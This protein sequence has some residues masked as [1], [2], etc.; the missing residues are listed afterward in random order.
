MNAIA[1]RSLSDNL[2]GINSA[3]SHFMKSLIQRLSILSIAASALDLT[4]GTVKIEG[5]KAPSAIVIKIHADLKAELKHEPVL[6]PP[7]DITFAAN[8]EP[9][10]LLAEM[11]RIEEIVKSNLK[12]GPV[13]V[14]DPKTI[15]TNPVFTRSDDM[16]TMKQGIMEM[17]TL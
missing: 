16:I 12:T 4:A 1:H 2:H 5:E 14:S 7:L 9:S 17:W 6:P 13:L 3:D 8:T 11:F 15:K 10:R